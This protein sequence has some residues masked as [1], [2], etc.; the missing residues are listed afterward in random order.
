MGIRGKTDHK[1]IAALVES[2]QQ[3][4][5]DALLK[6]YQLYSLPIYHYVRKRLYGSDEA[7]DVTQEVFLQLLLKLGELRDPQAFQAWL[8]RLASTQ[9]RIQR[10]KFARRQQAESAAP[11]EEESA[12][13]ASATPSPED[14]L[15]SSERRA[16]MLAHIAQLSDVQ[17][18]T[19]LFFYYVG[20]ST[21][22]IAQIQDVS[23]SAVRKRLHDARASLQK[24]L[25]PEEASAAEPD[26]LM[27]QVF[28]DAKDK[29]ADTR[30][31]REITLGLAAVAPMLIS[32]G[33]DPTTAAR[34]RVF[35]DGAAGKSSPLPAREGLSIFGKIALAAAALMLV[36]GSGYAL[37]RHN[38]A[39][40]SAAA[41]SPVP[42][43]Q[44]TPAPAPAPA[45]AQVPA[46]KPAAE[47]AT[48]QPA[49]QQTPQAAP[50]PQRPVITVARPSLSYATGTTLSPATIIADS[51]AAAKAADGTALPVTLAGLADVNTSHPGRYLCYAQATDTAG[52]GAKTLV[53]TVNI[54]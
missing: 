22:E 23:P 34:L 21:E 50:A 44:A 38:T 8:Y 1:Q 6:L 45:P 4:S 17:A 33:A 26:H 12:S 10:E 15:L 35:A 31:Q 28:Q 43:S 30:I 19:L 39:P 49:A 25:T 16:E 24:L 54:Q 3:G 46:Q 42:A 11:F 51:G 32:A 5:Q 9:C 18:D 53:I 13:I 48:A 52:V 41:P 27:R 7:L 2:A 40:A 36:A 14:A 29:H 47:G 37:Y 20:L